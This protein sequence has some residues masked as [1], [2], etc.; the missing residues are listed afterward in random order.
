MESYLLLVIIVIVIVILLCNNN[1][2]N[3]N[4]TTVS[5]VPNYPLSYIQ[6]VRIGRKVF[7]PNYHDLAIE[8][9]PRQHLG[10]N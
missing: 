10:P 7:D 9:A 4:F 3:A 8:R 1:K 5:P 2:E 6:G